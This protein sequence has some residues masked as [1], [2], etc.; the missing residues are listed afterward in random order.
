MSRQGLAET[1]KVDGY[2]LNRGCGRRKAMISR[3]RCMAAS[4]AGSFTVVVLVLACVGV[5]T[6]H[7]EPMPNGV[8]GT[9]QLKLNEEFSS[10]GLNTSLWTPGWQHGGLSEESERCLSSALVN[11]PGD[12][13]LHLWLHKETNTCESTHSE[14]TGSLVESNPND[15]VP[16]HTGFQYSYGYVE[17]RAYVVGTEEK[18]STGG[19][20]PDWPALW[21]LPGN[22]ETE[23]D[24]ME[25][26]NG[27]ACYH[28]HPPFPGGTG[29]CA[30]NRPGWNTYGENWEPGVV[31]FYYDGAQVGQVTS[32]KI[33]GTAQYLVM[34]MTAPCSC[35]GKLVAPDELDID[36]VRVWQHPPPAEPPEASTSAASEVHPTQAK[37]NGTV[38]PKGTDTHYYFQ[39]G[40]TTSYGSSTS[41]VDAGSG[42]NGQAESATLT[43]V[44]ADTL[45]HY[46]IVASNGAGTT[47]GGDMT[48]LTTKASF[49]GTSLADLIMCT[50]TDY[51]VAVSNG[52]ELNAPG[53]GVWSSW[54]CNRHTVIGDF[55]GDGEDDIAVPNESLG[56]WAVGVS[57]GAGSLEASGTNTWLKGWTTK[58]TWAAAGDFTGD[59][60]DDLIVCENNQYGVAISNG[61]ELNAP[62]SGIWSKWGCNAHAVV[63][64]FTGDGEDDI[65]VPNESLGTWAVGVSNGAGSLEASGTNTWLK[66]WTTKPTWAA[67]GDFTGDGKDDLIVCENGV[68][69]VAIST[70]AE[71]GG[72][73]TNV[74]L[75]APCNP[76]AVVGDF[77]G[78]GK[79]DIAIPDETTNTW[80]V[81]L[82]T[83]SSFEG[84]GSGTWLTG[85]GAQP[86][87][88]G[89]GE[90]GTFTPESGPPG[91]TTE[92]AT[93]VSGTAATLTGTVEPHGTETTYYAEYGPTTSYGTKVPASGAS[94]GAS[95]GIVAESVTISSLTEASIYHYRL[96]AT[97]SYGTSYGADQSLETS[98]LPWSLQTTT[99]PSGLATSKL[100]G[101]SCSSA[102][103]CTA[104]GWY[105]S[106]LG[107][108]ALLVERW[109]GTEW[110]TESAP[111]PSGAT[112]MSLTGVSCTSST[113]CVGTGGYVNS[114]GTGLTLAESWNGTEWTIK[115]TP[116]PSGATSSVLAGLSCTSSTACMAAGYDLNS[117]GKYVS[118]A[119]GWNGTEWTIKST[120]NPSGAQ[121]TVLQGVSCTSASACTAVG[122]YESSSGNWETLVER[123]NG[124]EWTI[125]TSPNLSGSTVSGLRGVS[126]TSST[127]CISTGDA[128]N[129][130]GAYVTLA[131][132]WNGSTW[133]V[134]TT[135]NPSG[136][137][138]SHLRAVSCASST[139]CTATGEYVNSSGTTVSLAEHWNG[140]E[141]SIQT[142]PI[143]S[144]AKE[145]DLQGASCT[146]STA[147]TSVGSYTNNQG[148]T[149]N[150]AEAY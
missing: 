94:A 62:G 86:M 53:S 137:K 85:W 111:S 150:L 40:T 10:S 55:T 113:A 134:Q 97:N 132:T 105:A 87:W 23:I 136:A 65:A 107:V 43:N 110:S 71:F 1:P 80:L 54:G 79:D 31:T 143:P 39:Y 74:W 128:V 48:V 109:N 83:G 149:I 98:T 70:G 41:E 112:T 35:G 3:S 133:T 66:G 99:N 141:W 69:A 114:S 108:S 26:L 125:Q 88:V 44:A 129:S 126:C 67:A 118:F 46:R 6:S 33:N 124:T 123:W 95:T 29:G 92:P 96:V 16:G 56:T 82:S 148:I 145:S 103:A 91:V 101:V 68:Y 90:G 30:G 84:S 135:P 57:N 139:V 140:T 127:A 4:L 11:Q 8:P 119:E 122:D 144:G 24:T 5:A 13:Y 25:G 47:Y 115:S 22:H 49:T 15:G 14:Y 130:S 34:D 93:G 7:A 75:H 121:A 142:T 81:Y 37:L 51:A 59:G 100:V 77:N 72:V 120:P 12:G 61:A 42:S 60:K 52:K 36:Y 78:D 147:C 64:D 104:T 106:G 138:N 50:T 58:P 131:E 89:V 38:N 32:S 17:W 146:S 27:E 21:S 63:G 76:H 116:N 45:Y 117:S 9:W 102:T 19:C 73:G 28:F 20:I 18:C 2:E